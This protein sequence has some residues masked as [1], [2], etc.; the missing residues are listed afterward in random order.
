MAEVTVKE[1]A[2]VVGIAVDRLLVQLSESGLPHN[3]ANEHIND[4]DKARLLSHLRRLHGKGDAESS[5]PKKISLKRKSVQELKIS[6]QG[7][8][9]TVTVEVRKRRTFVR[10]A[11]KQP[12]LQPATGGVEESDRMEA[13]KRAL[14]EEARRRHQEVDS[15]LRD[16]VEEREKLAAIE[17]QRQPEKPE[18][19]V[20]EAVEAATDA[21]ATKQPPAGETKHP[22]SDAGV[23]NTIE[24]RIVAEQAA[25]VAAQKGDVRKADRPAKKGRAKHDRTELHVASEKSGRRRKKAPKTRGPIKSAT[26]KHGFEMPTA[27]VVREVVVPETIS[28]D[29]LAQR[30]SIKASELIK[31]MMN[32][33][34]MVTIN[35]II[36][37]ETAAIVVEELG[38][39]PK[40][41]KD[42][43]LEDEVRVQEDD[44]RA[45]SPRSPVIT[46]MGHVDH[47]KTSLLDYIRRSKVADGEAGGITQHI[48]AYNVKTEKGSMTFLDTPGHAAF[49]AM[50]ARGA[51]ATDLVILVVAADDGVMPQTIE[52]IAHS[53]AANV[54]IIVA[55]N[56]MDREQADPDRVKQ[57]LASHGVI[58]DD[59]GGDTMFLGVSA[60]TGEGIDNLL[61]SILVQAEV[62]ELEA[63][64]SGPASGVVIESRLDRGRGPVASLL[65]QSGTLTKGDIILAGQEFGR[66]RGLYNEHGQELESAGPSTPVEVLGLSGPPAA[67]DE[68]MVVR[69]ERKAREV[70]LFRQGRYRD[71]RLARQQA[72]KLTNVFEQMSEGEV[73][74]LNIVIKADVQ[75]SVE[76]LR[77]A[78]VSLSHEEV[79]VSVVA[80]A[81][82]GISEKDVNLAIASDAIIIGFNVRADSGARKL[83]E[84]ESVELH[85][86]SIIYDVI[87]TV[88]QAIL[89]L[90]APAFKEEIVGIAQVRDVFRSR[91]FGSVAGCMVLEGAVKRNNP[92]RVLRDNVV[93]Y[94][95]ALESLRRFKEDALEVKSGTECGIGVKNYDDVKVGDQIEV[96]ERISVER[97]L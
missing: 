81:T 12:V 6:S 19:V 37:Q 38:H 89:G 93:I 24:E 26:T 40:L 30:M 8:K 72:S 34:S 56:K 65:V 1:L 42:S 67:G 82:G 41:V 69:D 36:D 76:A 16:E 52:A 33:G 85:Y 51:Q 80:S 14:Q 79:K 11:D 31:A 58:P 39:T 25:A 49:T 74:S 35:Q 66:V 5:A 44:G 57:A 75:G 78:L 59:W 97:T 10:S 53:K 4:E 2:E 23:S 9:K 27:P 47:G 13:A 83:I 84:E 71:V 20:E 92:I 87:D 45:L 29:E 50:R 17:R 77:D 60:K 18:P 32:L 3:A 7:R 63:A 15:Q 96:F 95:G 86:F 73:S 28:V 43:A 22:E 62:L 48:G 46:I 90:L 94:E 61:D 64:R 88:K 21:G 54:P 91:R 68:M 70:A 55:I